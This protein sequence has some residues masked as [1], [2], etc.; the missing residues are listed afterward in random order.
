MRMCSLIEKVNNPATC[1]SLASFISTFVA[2]TIQKLAASAAKFWISK[3]DIFTVALASKIQDPIFDS[4]FKQKKSDTPGD[5][6]EQREATGC[7][8]MPREAPWRPH[9]PVPAPRFCRSN[10]I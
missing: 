4:W 3:F 5:R 8:G 6:K 9:R 1:V 10:G 2:S 7:H